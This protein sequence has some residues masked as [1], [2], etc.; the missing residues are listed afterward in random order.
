VDADDY[1]DWC[2]TYVWELRQLGQADT[3]DTRLDALSAGG[4]DGHTAAWTLR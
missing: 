2:G 4:C 3:C 1:L